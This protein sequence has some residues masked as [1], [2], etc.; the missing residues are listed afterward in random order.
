MGRFGDQVERFRHYRRAAP[1]VT[2]GVAGVVA[3]AILIVATV[4]LPASKHAVAPSESASGLPA[5]GSPATTG[6]SGA[7]GADQPGAEAA[8]GSRSTAPEAAT[9]AAI[10]AA[11]RVHPRGIT[12]DEILIGAAYDKTAGAL[13]AAYGNVGIGQID[14]R[15]AI[16]HVRDYVN[17]HGG[18]AGRK[19]RIAW[20]EYDETSN[21][22]AETIAQEACA[23]WTQD[24][25]VFAVLAGS[26]FETLN[27]C[28]TK[29]GI[30]QVGIGSGSSDT[31]TYR[32]YP[33]AIDL[34]YPAIDRTARFA[35]DRLHAAEYYASGRSDQPKLPLKVGVVT[36][37]SPVY[38]RAVA[39]MRAELKR[40]GIPLAEV[41]QLKAY[42]STAEIPNEVAQIR[43]TVL[44]YKTRNV[45]HVQFLSTTSSFEASQFWEAADQQQYY[46]RYGVTSFEAA[47]ALKAT[48]EGANG[49]G[50][51]ARIFKD[52]MGVGWLPLSDQPREDY[53]A[54]KMSP[55][56]RRCESIISY[57]TFDDAA[58]YKE[59][60]AGWTCDSFFYLKAAIEAGGPTVNVRSWLEGVAKARPAS[61]VTFDMSTTATRHDAVGAVR[62]FR[63][64]DNCAC[65]HY[66]SG[67]KPV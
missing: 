16:E 4:T 28:L 55:A 49:Q 36:Y 10:R 35:V 67:L 38:D 19:I 8:S 6:L 25:H 43:Q 52:A 63:F 20:Y 44:R 56:L 26:G 24:H 14:Q 64:F 34:D 3:L 33:Y 57:E 30:V 32:D 42:Q 12:K 40:Y 29:N 62:D 2:L 60:V 59:T 61:A 31:K 48:T 23:T 66:T 41:S 13:N 51:F 54:A 18:I 22:S 15:K 58:R 50:S 46:P 39:A 9:A 65:F 11:A 45:T 5:A 47:Q 17:V 37:D 27:R 7:A 21:K 53:T 1:P